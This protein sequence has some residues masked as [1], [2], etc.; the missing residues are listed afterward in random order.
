MQNLKKL[1]ISSLPALSLCSHQA[2]AYIG[3]GMGAGTLG[4]LLG[5]LG[6][7]LLAL[8]AFFWYPIKR[9]FTGKGKAEKIPAEVTAE[10]T[11]Q[12]EQANTRDA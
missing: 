8:F 6:S 5:L 12:V 2:L 9:L 11:E 10:S 1:A 3:P 4:V 7:V